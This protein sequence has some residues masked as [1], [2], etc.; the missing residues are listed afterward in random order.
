[1]S[2]VELSG[3]AGG[4]LVSALPGTN[5][6]PVTDRLTGAL[7][8][9]TLRACLHGAIADARRTNGS[10]S[11]FFFDVDH[12]KSIN[13]AYGHARGDAILRILAE[14]TMALVRRGGVIVRYG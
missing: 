9:R 8:R 13:D 11:L 10:C 3:S 7:T 2:P 6:G 1:M 14:R 5:P 12:F 4:E